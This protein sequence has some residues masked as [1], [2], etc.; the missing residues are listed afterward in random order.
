MSVR[1]KLAVDPVELRDLM[2]VRHEVFVE[3]EGYMT[4]SDSGMIVDFF[5]AVSTTSNLIALVDGQVV[6]GSRI[7][8]DSDA[9]LPSDAAFDF[10]TVLPEGARLASGS[11]MCVKQG[12]RR[13][14]RLVQGL[15]RMM[16]Y[17][18][19]ASGCTHLCGPLNPKIRPFVERIGMVAVGDEFVDGKGLP[20]VP[21]VADLSKLSPSFQ[22]FV[23]R[24]DVSVWLDT[25]ERAF[26]EDGDVIIAEGERGDESFLLVEGT[27]EA[28]RPGLPI[29]AA[30]VVQTFARGDEF[31][32]L[33]LLTDR[34]RST[35][36]RAVG[37]TDAMVLRR[38]DF[39]RQLEE[40]TPITMKLLQSMGNRFHDAVSR[41]RPP[42]PTD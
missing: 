13:L 32:E 36:V 24:Q 9:G 16:F 6:G 26:Y 38:S 28:L 37:K 23:Q 20:T 17:R 34:P 5:D 10:R 29:A 33:A 42:E 2:R 15:F 4:P 39:H 25:F 1:V 27:A 18:A 41:Q 22:A 19:H 21:M 3:E 14:G 35:T 12:S 40:N 8:V 11:M 30:D 31:G 7:T